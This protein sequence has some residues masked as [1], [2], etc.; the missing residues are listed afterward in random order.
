LAQ[1]GGLGTDRLESTFLILCS[2]DG[3]LQSLFLEKLQAM[4]LTQGQ[5]FH[6]RFNHENTRMPHPLLWNGGA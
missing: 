4:Q 5:I 2:L 1:A 6:A 3:L